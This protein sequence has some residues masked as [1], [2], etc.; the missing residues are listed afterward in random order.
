[1]KTKE[2]VVECLY[3][4]LATKLENP[5]LG[6]FHSDSRLR[7]DLGLDSSATLQLLVALE[8]DFGLGLP[9]EVLMNQEL[10]TV[11]NVAKL[12][13]DAQPRPETGKILEF[14]AD[15]KLHCFV[16][17]LSE[18]L[19]RHEGIEHRIFYFGVWDSEIV[20]SDRM[21][22]SYHSE[23]IDHR[24]FNDWYRRLYG[25][26]VT[27]W[28][29]A[30]LDK[31]ENLARLVSLVE[32]RTPD[33]HIMVMLDMFQLPERVNEFNK[34][35]FP[36]YLMLGPTRNPDEW[37]MYDPDYRWE[38]VIRKERILQAARHPSVA[39]GYVFSDSTLRAPQPEAIAAYFDAC[40]RP[41]ENPMTSA[42]RRVL[43][44][45]L[46]GRDALGGELPL[47][48]VGDALAE[49]PILAIRKYAYE[50][51][52]A[53][54]WRELGLDEDE[55]DRWCEAIDELA[56]AFKV[57]QFQAMK[58][59]ASGN[60]ALADR[61]FGLLKEQD[62]REFRIKARLVEV[63]RRWWEST[64]VHRGAARPSEATP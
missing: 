25:V 11:R 39:G 15:I 29:D 26:P 6:T 9:E 3:E 64:S 21:V 32:N 54:Y 28:Y 31:D 42:I 35:P 57:V 58:L 16:S 12:L 37:M 47:S 33:Q 36:H 45:H 40:M 61:I 18:V 41:D 62:E 51:G 2:Q 4:V 30:A 48:A 50:H 23:T 43:T 24:H 27:A 5:Y 38:G 60:R 46:E 34:D 59:A 44:A 56:K 20:V 53:F 17:C 8:L 13:Y 22:V 49:V 7:E 1:M 63:H 55:F 10:D 19:K 14:E 52:L